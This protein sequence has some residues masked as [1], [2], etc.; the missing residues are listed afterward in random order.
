MSTPID[1]ARA[2]QGAAS[3]P[4]AAARSSTQPAS[5]AQPAPHFLMTVVIIALIAATAVW[6]VNEFSLP[7]WM[8]YLGW[9]AFAV[10]GG[11]PRQSGAMLGCVLMGILLGMAG[12]IEMR[13]MSSLGGL[14]LPIMVF[15]V[16]AI[17]VTAQRVPVFDKVVGYFIGMTGYFASGLDPGAEGFGTLAAAAI[18]GTAAGWVAVRLPALAVRPGSPK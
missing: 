17:A 16:T 11:T 1:K 8:L 2:P 5:G 3:E 15:S 12:M 10:A 9:I 14:A 7:A 6:I 13:A 18:A 4:Q